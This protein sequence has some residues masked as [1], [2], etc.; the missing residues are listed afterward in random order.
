[1]LQSAYCLERRDVRAERSRAWI[2]CLQSSL[3][4]MYSYRAVEE[5]TQSSRY[6]TH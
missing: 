3:P 1:M 4:V 5:S 2:N 6:F